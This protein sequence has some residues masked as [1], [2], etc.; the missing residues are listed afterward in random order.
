MYPVSSRIVKG[1]LTTYK[2]SI[3][4]FKKIVHFYFMYMTVYQ[5]KY[6]YTPHVFLVPMEFRIGFLGITVTDG[7]ELPC[8][9]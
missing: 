3:T 9:S 2:T 1:F 4:V 5:P 7:H 6:V 8:G